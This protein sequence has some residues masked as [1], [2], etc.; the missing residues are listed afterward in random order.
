LLRQRQIHTQQ[1]KIDP[2][3]IVANTLLQMSS[4]ELQQAIE[5]ELAENPALE[6]EDEQPC[7]GCEMSPFMCEDCPNNP[8]H[9]QDASIDEISLED[10]ECMFDATADNAAAEQD[11]PV[12]RIQAE[13]SLQESLREQLRGIASG[14]L[15]EIGDY[16]INYIDDNG[17]LKC[18]LLEI[19]LEIDATDEEIEQAVS[20]IQMLE[21]PGVGA[22]DLRECLLIQLRFLAEEGRGN[23]V[24]ERIVQDY[25]EEMKA[26]KLTR[27]ARRLKVKLDKVVEAIEFIQT[28]LNPYPAASFRLPWEHRTYDAKDVVQ[29]DVIIKRTPAGYEVEVVGNE[30]TALSVN[31]YYRHIYN[32]LRNGRSRSYSDQEKKHII[33]Y[34]ERA[35]LF[36]RS[37]NQRRKTLKSI[38]KCIA[39]LQHGFLD[40][41]SKLYLRPLTR[42]KVAEMLGL[43][44]STVSRATA[45]KYVQLPN[46][47]VVP[48]DF[49]F[50]SSPSISDMIAQL[51]ANEDKSRPLSD[52][53]IANILT[54]RGYPIARRTVVKYRE[55]QKI[56]SSRQRK[57][58]AM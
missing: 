22:R 42:I 52:Q 23:P 45:N 4:L 19:T 48:F 50:Q 1:Q 49:F 2:K 44:E 36:I 40:T 57:L 10:I 30:L 31:P 21:P 26:R 47:E 18:D 25:W 13:V 33:E 12:T 51:I 53:E 20:L 34:V 7:T 24:A 41:G 54:E 35:D 5:Q 28:R 14:K 55:A 39:D 29:P 9:Q 56:L 6:Q 46:E 3:I 32:E 38:T 17:Y 43:H 37:L 8:K 58:R 11:D 16:L 15:L 27:I